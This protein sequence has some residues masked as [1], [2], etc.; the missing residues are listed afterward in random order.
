MTGHPYQNRLCDMFI[1]LAQAFGIL[2]VDYKRGKLHGVLVLGQ[3]I[4][5]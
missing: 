3:L 2:P 4:V 5:I 1:F